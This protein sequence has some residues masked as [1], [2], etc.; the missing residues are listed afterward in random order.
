LTNINASQLGRNLVEQPFASSQ[1]V[2]E[3]KGVLGSFE[4]LI[5]EWYIAGIAICGIFGGLYLASPHHAVA[6]RVLP[7]PT[8]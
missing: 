7:T 4:R 5:R 8:P 2:T 1:D 3:L 6:I